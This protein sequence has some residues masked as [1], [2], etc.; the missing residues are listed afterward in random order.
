MSTSGC[1]EFES[2]HTLKHV[3]SM[4]FLT[5]STVYSTL[6]FAGLLRPATDH[7]VRLVLSRPPT[8]PLHVRPSSQALSTLRSFSLPGSGPPCHQGSSP[9]VVSATV[10]EVSVLPRPQGIV[11]PKNPLLATGVATNSPPDA[12]LGFL[13]LPALTVSPQNLSWFVCHLP[14]QLTAL[15]PK[16]SV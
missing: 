10:T 2:C 11:P 6:S 13:R 16:W 15:P 1:P 4:S 9:P 5:T 8:S 3:P 14:K 12:P 7:E